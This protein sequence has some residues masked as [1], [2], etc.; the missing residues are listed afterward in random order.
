[1]L[2]TSVFG[3]GDGYQPL[4]FRR[5]SSRSAG[6]AREHVGGELGPDRGPT[7]AWAGDVLETS[8][9]RIAEGFTRQ[10]PGTLLRQ[11]MRIA[12]SGGA[13]PNV[14]ARDDEAVKLF[15]PTNPRA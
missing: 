11:Q 2:R 13:L 12:G 9:H 15:T 6:F 10:T 3:R 5:L 7:V 1:M 14:A 4:F 8:E